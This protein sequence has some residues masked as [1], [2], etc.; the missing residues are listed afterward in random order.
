[1]LR[2]SANLGFLWNDLPL[3][4]GIRRAHQAGFAAVE[5]HWPYDEEPEEVRRALAETGLPL[6]GLNTRKGDR[7]GDFGL[8][9]IPGREGEARAAIDEAFAFARSVGARAV[10]V[11]AGKA[12]WNEASLRSF[13]D[14]L[15]HACD[16]ALAQEITVLI[17]P[18]NPRDV[19][20]YALTTLEDAVT[21]RER[22][23]REELKILFDCYHL[24]IM[25]GDLTHRFES[26]KE[27][28]GHIQIASVPA[29]AEPDEGE[30]AYERLL[31]A[32][33]AQGWTGYV[34][35][36]YK[37]RAGTDAGLGWLEAYRPL[38]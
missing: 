22:L 35:A 5:C 23:G 1:M 32:F 19:P 30:I 9:A 11:M 26:V 15:A 20:G 36:E 16:L 33:D 4:E 28:V 29:R 2:F 3:A 21:V 31:A 14:N 6:L 10:H 27:A 37:P 7:P 12:E 38:S 25:G 18:I 17:E 24:Q 34:G 13:A 8:S